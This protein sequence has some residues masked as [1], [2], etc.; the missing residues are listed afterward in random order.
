MSDDEWPPI[1]SEEYKNFINELLNIK[2]CDIDELFNFNIGSEDD[3]DDTLTDQTNNIST[4]E[5]FLQ[6][7]FDKQNMKSDK[8]SNNKLIWKYKDCKKC[9]SN[10]WNVSVQYTRDP[11]G[12]DI[13]LF[14]CKIC[15]T[16]FK[17]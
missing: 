10:D 8:D 13:S 12:P 16:V 15:D 2:Y 6:D 14:H 5:A 11:F 7:F 1:K 3:N 4:G 9:G 17:Q